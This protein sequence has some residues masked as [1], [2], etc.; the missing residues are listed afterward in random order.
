M[1]GG[2][3]MK[4]YL[5]RTL[6]IVLSL[7][8][9][10]SYNMSI[11]Y[12]EPDYM[13][14]GKSYMDAGNYE[15]AI[16]YFDLMIKE[17]IDEQ[18]AYFKGAECLYQ[19]GDYSK[20]LAY[21]EIGILM[22]PS[23]ATASIYLLKGM[24][25]IQYKNYLDSLKALIVAATKEPKNPEIQLTKGAALFGLKRYDE[26]IGCFNIAIA[27]APYEPVYYITKISSLLMLSKDD[28]ALKVVDEALK[29]PK[30]LASTEV[31]AML[32][33]FKGRA[34][35]N[36][37]SYE[38]ALAAF[39]KT[40]DL[41]EMVDNDIYIAK[42]YSNLGKNEEA[43]KILNYH[44]DNNPTNSNVYSSYGVVLNNLERYNEAIMYFDSAIQ[45]DPN[46][47]E[48]YLNKGL[49]TF[50][51]G[52]IK[53]SIL[54]FDKAIQ[55]YPTLAA[56]YVHKG[57]AYYELGQYEQAVKCY[58]EAI[59]SKAINKVIYS[60]KGFVLY[61][62][63]KYADAINSFDKSIALDNAYR[64]ALRG[65]LLTLNELKKFNEAI[66]L[67]DSMIKLDA[68][69]VLPL[70]SKGKALAGLGKYKDAIALID[71]SLKMNP[72]NAMAY[73]EKANVL[74]KTNDLE[75]AI[76]NYD[77]AL[78]YSENYKKYS[79]ARIAA[80]TALAKKNAGLSISKT[81]TNVSVGK[82]EKLIVAA[83]PGFKL[84][85]TLIWTS[86]N[87]KVAAVD[88]T[89][90]VKGVAA[91]ETIIYATSSDKKVK[92]FCKVIITK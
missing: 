85:K 51:M 81:S 54:F 40:Y 70:V 22:D 25:L 47:H 53:D 84:N 86:S 10:L 64:D 56:P 4:L 17:D 76:R 72:K 21:C 30:A 44:I 2:V 60:E 9:L 19:L 75:G 91:G 35:Y 83:L 11:I 23:K 68:K 24:G 42:T 61:Y 71:N 90:T 69:D 73:Y 18:Q 45:I 65:K 26:A 49:S 63:N 57:Y 38:D 7:V 36:L 12:A 62:M 34:L 29:L 46:N 78:L 1:N 89:G 16:K 8:I 79:E 88:K 28:E 52:K 41:I 5:K 67:A 37:E 27:N 20:S 77:M 6:L 43:V 80:V 87:P 74:V 50:Y 48:A 66:V 39:L 32:Y 15:E 13:S 14:L 59:K 55:L 92:L 33:H 82:T 3:Q 58:D 31:Q